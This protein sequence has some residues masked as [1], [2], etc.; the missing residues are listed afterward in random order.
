MRYQTFDKKVQL[1]PKNSH[2]ISILGNDCVKFAIFTLFL[3]FISQLSIFCGIRFYHS[4]EKIQ[5]FPEKNFIWRKRLDDWKL[6]GSLGSPLRSLS[7]HSDQ[8]KGF[9]RA[10]KDVQS[11]NNPEN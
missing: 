10:L 7:L 3:Q 5:I 4:E 6:L 1:I 11:E 8:F 9:C 2:G